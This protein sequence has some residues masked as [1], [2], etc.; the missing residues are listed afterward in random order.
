MPF[1][2]SI[3]AVAAGEVT[4]LPADH[5][6]SGEIIF[7]RLLAL[8][9]LVLLNGFFVASEL[10]IVKIRGSQLDALIEQG[11]ARALVTKHITD[12]LESYISATQ[13]GITLASLG[14]GWLGEPF[15]AHMIEPAFAL[16]G[17][18]STVIITTV[19]FVIAFSLIT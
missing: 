6:E 3:L 13:L 15:L 12:H 18:S 17:I 14:L 10:A 19:S 16:I 5:W 9:A 7:L 1:V 4:Y 8:L 11:D 2:A